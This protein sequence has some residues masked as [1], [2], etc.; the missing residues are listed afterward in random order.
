MVE[1][2]RTGLDAAGVR[3][4]FR[5]PWV[6]HVRELSVRAHG[7]AGALCELRDVPFGALESLSLEEVV[8]LPTL[9]V[10]LDAPWMSRVSRLR[11]GESDLLNGDAAVE[12]LW[13]RA[14]HLQ[15]LR[16]PGQFS[17][18][19]FSREGRARLRAFLRRE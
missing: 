17:C 14:E 9:E 3:A 7:L 2:S 4:L 1:L 13:S 8:D 5:A 15:A 10:L 18:S 12:A 16:A 11:L 19:W 6:E